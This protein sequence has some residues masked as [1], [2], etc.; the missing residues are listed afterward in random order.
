MRHLTV[1]R[2]HGG[3][4]GDGIWR[5]DLVARCASQACIVKWKEGGD[6]EE[7]REKKQLMF[8]HVEAVVKRNIENIVRLV[9][10]K[11]VRE[12]AAKRKEKKKNERKKSKITLLVNDIVKSLPECFS[13]INERK[14]RKFNFTKIF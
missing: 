12:C 11:V 5:S 10:A 7:S 2:Y 13:Q 9:Y 6:K 3:R 4:L 8:D 14:R 1:V